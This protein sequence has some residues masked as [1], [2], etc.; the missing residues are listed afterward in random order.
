MKG[1]IGKKAGMT[2]VFIDGKHMGVTVIDVSD[3]RVAQVKTMDTDGYNAIQVAYDTKREKSVIKPE[4]GHFKKAGIEAKRK[5]VEFRDFSFE[6]NVG[7][8]IGT[9]IFTEGEKV[10]VIGVSKGKGFQGVVKRHNFSG[11]G[12][13]THGQHDR[14][15]APGSI[16]A[17]SDPSRVLKGMRMAGRMG[18][19]RITTKNVKIVKIMAENN[20]I[21]V[22][23][24]VPGAIGCYLTIESK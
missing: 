21:L 10:A 3:N 7:D 9:E 16:G 22:N 1:I 12:M 20:L 13:A 24:S 19:D 14:Q 17:S 6:K 5:L 15:R 8:V 4:A 2:S 18:G 23:G 11:V